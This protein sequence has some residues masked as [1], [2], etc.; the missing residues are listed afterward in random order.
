MNKLCAGIF[1]HPQQ[2]AGL[3]LSPWWARGPGRGW[4][5]ALPGTIGV[6]TRN[7]APAARPRSHGLYSIIRLSSATER[8]E[9]RRRLKCRR[10]ARTTNGRN[11]T[12]AANT[13]VVF[14][15][16]R[17]PW[18]SH[19]E[20]SG[21][22]IFILTGVIASWTPMKKV[23]NRSG[24]MQYRPP[25]SAEWRQLKSQSKQAKASHIF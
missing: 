11:A 23:R 20:A 8:P 1:K 3:G 2:A 19:S 18:S 9:W 21:K 16:T 7:S 25:R 10:P 15:T 17:I 24:L 14:T 5:A 6:L 4:V 22:T 13:K 12:I